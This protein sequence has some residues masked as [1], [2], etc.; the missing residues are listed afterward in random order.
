VADIQPSILSSV[1]SSYVD[2]MAAIHKED[3][4]EMFASLHAQI[5]R[6]SAVSVSMRMTDLPR[7]TLNGHAAEADQACKIAAHA[8][9]AH[10]TSP[11]QSAAASDPAK[12]ASTSTSSAGGSITPFQALRI[13]LGQLV[14]LMLKER[15]FC[16]DFFRLESS[17]E[18]EKAEGKEAEGDNDEED[19]EEEE[20]E[21]GEEE[22]E[23]GGGGEED[24][25]ERE[26]EGGEVVDRA[27]AIIS[28]L[29]HKTDKR[30]IKLVDAG[31]AGGG[32]DQMGVLRM[33]LYV[34]KLLYYT[35]HA[36]DD[37]GVHSVHSIPG[38][39][40]EPNGSNAETDRAPGNVTCLFLSS[41]LTKLQ[42]YLKQSFCKF[43]DEQEQWINSKQVGP[44]PLDCWC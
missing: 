39:G 28:E 33:I 17:G 22:E 37:N 4:K 23:E 13:A 5:G 27:N 9:A 15:K 35:N 42:L 20:E 12:A 24:D 21:K 30:L 38:E 32:S 1:K 26:R 16:C 10:V 25:D 3:T 31:G 36:A 19:E 34:E 11:S 7:C 18:E 8:C 40:A 41:V 14:P 2:N 44:C 43:M 6:S 29:F